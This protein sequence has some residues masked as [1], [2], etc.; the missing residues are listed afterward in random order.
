MLLDLDGFKGINDRHGHATGDEL[1]AWV[2]A[3][4]KGVVRPMDTMGRIG[5]DEFAVLVPGTP[6]ADTEELGVRIGA[7]LAER[8]A[9]TAGTASFP[10]DGLDLDELY[11]AADRE[12]YLGKSA[13]AEPASGRRDLSWAETLASA[14]SRRMGNAGEPSGVARIATG[15]ADRMGWEGQEL[16]SFALAA[17][18]QDVGKLPVPDRILKKPGPLEPGELAEVRRHLARGAE[19]V[20]RVA[21]MGPV[22]G[23]LRHAHEN[24]DG[25]GYPD[26]LRGEEIPLPSR[27]LRV[28]SAF[29][30]MT[31]DRPYRAALTTDAALEQ[32]RRNTGKEFDPRCVRELEELIGSEAEP[33]GASGAGLSGELA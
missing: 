23:W 30:A 28:V 10:E 27:L 11:H 21:G 15:L 24:Y 26:R 6:R 9:V 7:A 4:I 16:E 29:V 22:A 32:L 33:A 3:A 17:L 13:N 8:I 25:S 5:G 2:A 14:V 12:L 19:S 20:S 1:L 18:V 31:S